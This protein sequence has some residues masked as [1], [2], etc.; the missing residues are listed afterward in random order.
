MGMNR[1]TRRTPA[2][3]DGKRQCRMCD[4]WLEV[5][6][7]FYPRKTGGYLSYCKTCDKKAAV[8]RDRRNRAIERTKAANKILERKKHDCKTRDLLAQV[9]VFMSNQFP[10]MDL[11]FEIQ[12]HVALGSKIFGYSTTV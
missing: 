9:S 8:T 7:N 3:V 4:Q 10:D 2:V 5:T 12:S 1:R 6:Q 11:T